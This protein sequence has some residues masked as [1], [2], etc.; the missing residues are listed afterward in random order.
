MIGSYVLVLCG[1]PGLTELALRAMRGSTA[2]RAVAERGDVHPPAPACRATAAGTPGRQSAARR[3]CLEVVVRSVV[4][5]VALSGARF[6][7]RP[8]ITESRALPGRSPRRPPIQGG[9]DLRGV[10]LSAI[11]RPDGA[12]GTAAVTSG[13]RDSL[14]RPR[15]ASRCSAEVDPESHAL[16]ETNTLRRCWRS[17]LPPPS[18]RRWRRRE[19]GRPG[20]QSFRVEAGPVPPAIGADTALTVQLRG[21]ECPVALRTSAV[22]RPAPASSEKPGSW[23]RSR[24]T[25]IS[26]V[27]SSRTRLAAPDS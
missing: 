26:P 21:D 1:R 4:S 5:E 12:P 25:P 8:R 27:T 6:G 22:R 14:L 16:P 13:H 2:P 18:P 17:A 15:G 24:S 9:S 20:R 19:G 11:C 10:A 7:K 23:R 3:F